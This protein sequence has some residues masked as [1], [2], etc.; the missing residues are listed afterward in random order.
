MIA[1][2]RLP[3]ADLNEKPAA[4]ETDQ[5]AIRHRK[6]TIYLVTGATGFLGTHLV[7]QL[8]LEPDVRLRLLCRS[9]SRWDNDSR[10]E[11]ARGD[12]LEAQRVNQVLAGV[13]GIF[14]LA[15]LVSRD[16]R[17][18]SR[19]F[20]IHVQGTRNLFEAAL[21]RGGPRIVLV[22]SSGTLAASSKPVMHD[23]ASPYASDVVKNWPYY[24]SK[25]SQEQLAWSYYQTHQLPLVVVNPSLLLGPGDDRL[26]S[27]GDVAM[28]LGG[29]IKNYP[30]GGLNFV[31]VRDT[32]A[33]IIRA[34]TRGRPGARYLIG[35]HNMSFKQFF[36][37]ASRIAGR[38]APLLPISE[39]LAVLYTRLKSW[40]YRRRKKNY[41][42]DLV[43]VRMAFRYWYFRNDRAVQELGLRFRP[44][45]E[46]L[47]DTIQYLRSRSG[48]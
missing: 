14:H 7:K 3:I 46:T 26:S 42:L 41:P 22:S 13:D 38:R 28:L 20:E 25:I 2:C 9:A 4:T 21:I 37:L 33:A 27:T 18:A 35:A 29:Y 39:S 6:S 40:L 17:D 1:D 12:V 10:V 48:S 23:E 19:M 47:R 31:D 30:S 45:E 44:A 43:S 32:A 36:R 34:M 8:L 16:P 24:A 11:V 5:S 15:G